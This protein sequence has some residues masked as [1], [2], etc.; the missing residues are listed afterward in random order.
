MGGIVQQ[1]SPCPQVSQYDFN[2]PGWNANA[3]HF[4]QLVWKSTA[5]V[6]C[7]TKTSGSGFA[8]GL[9]R[10]EPMPTWHCSCRSPRLAQ[11][12]LEA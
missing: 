4:T 11:S 10:S 12:V 3:A 7:A 6:G 1:H 8:L 9:V 2:N 5:N